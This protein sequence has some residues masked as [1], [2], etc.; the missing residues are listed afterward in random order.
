MNYLMKYSNF[1]KSSPNSKIHESSENDYYEV[2]DIEVW[3]I[4]Y[5]I[6]LVRYAKFN[7]TLQRYHKHPRVGED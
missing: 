7:F 6:Q 1:T 5:A 4:P 2:S 3:H